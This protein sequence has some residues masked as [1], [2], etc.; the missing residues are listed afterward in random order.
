M[1]MPLFCCNL[2]IR[3]TPSI[4]LYE[5]FVIVTSS[6]TQRGRGR[7]FPCDAFER[8]V[9]HSCRCHSVVRVCCRQSHG[10]PARPL[11]CLGGLELPE[12]CRRPQVEA[13]A[14]VRKAKAGPDLPVEGTTV[15]ARVQSASVQSHRLVAL[16]AALRHHVRL[17]GQSALC[18]HTQRPLRRSRCSSAPHT[19]RELRTTSCSF[20]SPLIAADEVRSLSRRNLSS[21]LG[22]LFGRLHCPGLLCLDA[23]RPFQHLHIC[24]LSTGTDCIATICS[25]IK[26]RRNHFGL[27]SF[28][29]R[30]SAAVIANS[31][32]FRFASLF[33]SRGRKINAS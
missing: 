29:K 32:A 10:C 33:L 31:F 2:A 28:A 14:R 24:T 13:I 22:F 30:A 7:C 25:M 1:H 23:L 8:T 17:S 21:A 4:R 16:P 9:S 20:P 3:E 11:P 18:R 27:P 5:L 15:R 6:A 19:T 12:L 26:C